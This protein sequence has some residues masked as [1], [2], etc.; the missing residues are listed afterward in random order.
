M[1]WKTRPLF[2][3]KSLREFYPLSCAENEPLVLENVESWAP[4]GYEAAISEVPYDGGYPPLPT[5][6][7]GTE[8]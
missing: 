6:A 5:E 3:K 8:V 4:T 1:N 2:T 7:I